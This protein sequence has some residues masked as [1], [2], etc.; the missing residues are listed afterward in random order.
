MRLRWTV[1]R[2]PQCHTVHSRLCR[3]INHH[4]RSP[5]CLLKYPRSR[6]HRLVHPRRASSC[7]TTTSFRKIAL[8][9]RQASASLTMKRRSRSRC[10]ISTSTPPSSTS[11]RRNSSRSTMA[12][13]RRPIQVTGVPARPPNLRCRRAPISLCRRWSVRGST[14]GELLEKILKVTLAIIFP[15]LELIR[16]IRN[17]LLF[18]KYA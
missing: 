14:L 18:S 12:G 1:R 6:I 11:L 17:I 3:S 2:L 16:S 15:V 7:W 13:H 8:L 10:P 9:C 4:R 5:S